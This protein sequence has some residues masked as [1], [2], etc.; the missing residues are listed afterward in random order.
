MHASNHAAILKSLAGVNWRV[1]HSQFENHYDTTTFMFTNAKVFRQQL[2]VEVVWGPIALTLRLTSE[3]VD[4]IAAARAVHTTLCASLLDPTGLAA[5][6]PAAHAL[7]FTLASNVTDNAL[8]L[9]GQIRAATS[10]ASGGVT[11]PTPGAASAAAGGEEVM[12]HGLIA[13]AGAC[14]SSAPST[15]VRPREL[16]EV[17][18]RAV[19]A[20][21]RGAVDA[22]AALKGM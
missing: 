15:P 19:A 3:E 17:L 18:S 2:G 5:S 9:W 10:A 16:T 13:T 20:V 12:S 11:G 21:G 8:M 6:H 4:R 7:V 22:V 14:G 1:G